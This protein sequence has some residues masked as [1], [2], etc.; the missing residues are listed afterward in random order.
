MF[1]LFLFGAVYIFERNSGGSW[2]EKASFHFID[3]KANDMFG[4][5]V[6]ISGRYTAVETSGF[7]N[8]NYVDVYY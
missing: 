5:S 6:A 7:N 2:V 3:M 1:L 4:C 8:V